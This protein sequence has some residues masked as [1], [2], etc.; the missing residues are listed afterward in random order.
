MIKSPVGPNGTEPSDPSL[1]SG[2]L[3]DAPT[4]RAEREAL[5][6]GSAR[7]VKW[8]GFEV[9]V[10]N[11]PYG[12]GSASVAERSSDGTPTTGGDLTPGAVV[13]VLASFGGSVSEATIGGIGKTAVSASTMGSGGSEGAALGTTAVSG[14]DMTF[15][16]SWDA[17]VASAPAAFETDVLAAFQ[18]YANLFTN[19]VTLY[20][21]VGYG[22]FDGIPLSSGDLGE[23]EEFFGPTQTY[24]ALRS[25]MIADAQSPTQNAA[26]ATLPATNPTG[27]KTL[28]MTVAEEKALGFTNLGMAGTSFANPDGDV[29]LSSTADFSYS[30]TATPASNQYYFLGVAE[31]EIS[32]V[33]GRIS[34]LGDDGSPDSDYSPMD[35]F[36]YAASG[37]RQLTTGNPSYFTIN[38]GLTNLNNWNNFTT[39]NTGDL[40]DWAPS[41]GDDSYLDNTNAGVI[42]PV[43]P[44][45]VTLMNV[46][47]WDTTTVGLPAP[48]V[49]VNVQNVSVGESAS[50][51]ALSMITSLTNPSGD[52]V[53]QYVFEDEGGGNG[54]FT[55]NGTVQADGQLIFVTAAALSSIQYVGGSSPGSETLAVAAFD[56]TTNSYSNFSS[57]TATT[58]G[59]PLP[60][61]GEQVLW[62]NPITGDTGYW[63]TNT[64][65]A[66]A[67]FFDLA[68]GNTAYSIVGVGD[69]DGSGHDEVLWENKAT[70]DT[71][72]WTT[73][74]S[75]AITG[76]HDF[77]DGNTTY[78]IVGVGD[79]DGSGHDEV[80]WEN[81]ATGDTGYWTT[82]ASGA[83]T[84]F[85]DFG[86][87]STAYS[88]VGVG[89]FD[90]SGLSKS[91]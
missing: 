86:A 16:I 5:I 91:P 80:L 68:E 62:E 6:A 89:D 1:N 49:V 64:S 70:G 36:R 18:F 76:F 31:H 46:I 77:A 42:N 56:A 38:D 21:N 45:D 10:G 73:N 19:K 60:S 2:W 79:F 51:A 9:P 82:N 63:V 4:D 78:S 44:T 55:V 22:E 54:H 53:T 48:S 50:I 71:G 26:V 69:F 17:S 52:S 35:L 57:L 58:T 47:G 87:M 11:M 8:V 37:T 34:R 66:V 29:G 33:M 23:N 88:V 67:S 74:A 43:T 72:Y 40:G 27:G 39:G 85:H 84:G 7:P 83:V 25:Q 65:G 12:L 14:P 30:L 81:K 15:E 90:G 41:A 13:D 20:Y 59:T 28:Q 75:G 32:E 24:A 3:D 61:L